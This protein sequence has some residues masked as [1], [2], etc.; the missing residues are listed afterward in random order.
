M[1]DTQNFIDTLEIIK[2]HAVKK[3]KPYTLK[4]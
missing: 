4:G 1:M 2:S 3:N